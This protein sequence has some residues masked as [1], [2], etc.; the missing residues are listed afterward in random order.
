[1]LPDLT[2]GAMA[3][4][5]IFMT[6]DAVGGIWQYAIDLAR[7]LC[8]QGAEVT[9]AVLGPPPTAI[10]CAETDDIG[11][12]RLLLTGL[13]LDWTASDAASVRLAAA[14]IRVLI[15]RTGA[16]LVHLNHAA[17]AAGPGFG[18]PCLVAC[19]SCVA[20]WWQAVR[21]GDLPADLAWRCDLVAAGYAAADQLL[22]PSAAFAAETEA[23]YGVTP[24]VVHNGRA[25]T[26][27]GHTLPSLPA[28]FAFTAGRLWDE[29]KSV[30]VLDRVAEIIK[31]PFLAAG[32]LQGP[33]GANIRLA[34][35]RHCGDL[36]SGGMA[37]H[38]AAA[39]VFVSAARY[40][41]FGLAV[42]EAAQAGC[43]LVLS[44]IG[45]LREIWGDAADYVDCDDVAGF[46]A[47]V[48]RLIDQP[49][50]RRGRGAAAADRASRYTAGAMVHGTT[51]LYAELLDGFLKTERVAMAAGA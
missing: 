22:A 18:V 43:A 44:D 10:Q 23:C 34:H 3:G 4:R 38:L 21:G 20:T 14:A 8:A 28:D 11:G 32:P 37:A 41:P 50:L 29:G 2:G 31:A 25:R 35:L 46:A 27:G 16:E 48:G 45:S 9:L 5:R 47:A 7:G 51:A 1:M 15:G 30:A 39:S 36:D 19:H 13:P 6:A 40:E 42:L 24:R 49:S 17:L 33:N 26:G 12:L